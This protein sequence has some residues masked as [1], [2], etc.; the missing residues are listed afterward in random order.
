ML[1][2]I[3]NKNISYFMF[4]HLITCLIFAIIYNKLFDNIDKHFIMN[5]SI[6]KE[7][8]MKNKSINSLYLSINMQTSTGYVDVALRSPLIK[9]IAGCQLLIS[10]FISL[11][12]IYISLSVHK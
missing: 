3:F 11:G 1:K 10:L 2:F 6:T 9:L 12:V 8:Y 7:E 4:S 5:S